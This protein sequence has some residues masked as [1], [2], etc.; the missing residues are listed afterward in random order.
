MLELPAT[1]VLQVNVGVGFPPTPR[2][3]RVQFLFRG[4]QLGGDR[5]TMPWKRSPWNVGIYIL[6]DYATMPTLK[7]HDIIDRFMIDM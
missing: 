6:G 3:L 2:T 4:G 1:S 7:L 5:L